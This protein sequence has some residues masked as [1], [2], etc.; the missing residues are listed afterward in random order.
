LLGIFGIPRTLTGWLGCNDV[1]RPEDPHWIIVLGG[2]GIPSASSLMRSY[3][4]AQCALA[5]AR[6]ECIVALAS[7]D[8][9]LAS[10]VG[11]L[12]H[13]LIV[14]GVAPERIRMEH[15]GRN[16][17]EQAVNIARML[18]P[19][20]RREAVVL[21]TSPYHMRRAYLCFRQAGFENV[22]ALPSYSI[23]SEEEYRNAVEAWSGFGGVR[24]FL[25]RFRYSFWINLTAEIW[26]AREL[27]GL[28]LYKVR[29]WI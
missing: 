26:I 22:G 3:Y 23:G 17:H 20:G 10:N 13:E 18:G 2:S 7:A 6:A 28:A 1:P 19:A 16:T 4:G 21:V 11:R 24:S 25:G 12:R 8:D 14:R 27:T 9:P 5:H 15:K 29:G